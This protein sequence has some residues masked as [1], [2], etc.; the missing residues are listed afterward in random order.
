MIRWSV[1]RTHQGEFLGIPPTGKRVTYGGIDIF[2]V[3][4]GKLVEMWQEVDRLGLL[5]QLGVIPAAEHSAR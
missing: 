3:A 5:Q 4:G 1:Q 2:R